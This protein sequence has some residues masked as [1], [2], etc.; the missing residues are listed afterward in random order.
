MVEVSLYSRS[1]ATCTRFDVA[2][3]ALVGKS[4]V[5][6]ASV[7]EPARGIHSYGR[8]NLMRPQALVVLQNPLVQQ[9]RFDALQPV[10]VYI[11]IHIYT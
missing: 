10:C 2:R 7:C 11:Y 9:A 8:V 4:G 5:I 3:R 6:L 1:P